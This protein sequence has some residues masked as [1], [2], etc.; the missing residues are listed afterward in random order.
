MGGQTNYP[1]HGKGPVAHLSGHR[2]HLFPVCSGFME[3]RSLITDDG[4]VLSYKTASLGDAE[5]EYLEPIVH[6]GFNI[7]YHDDRSGVSQPEWARWTI[8]GDL[9]RILDYDLAPGAED[10]R[11]YEI[12][13][14]IC[15][16]AE[17]RGV[18][19]L[20]NQSEETA[21]WLYTASLDD[22]K[23]VV[24]TLHDLGYNND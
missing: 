10:Y 17:R 9:R 6:D 11:N 1:N 20:V 15:E 18:E 23:K 22:A 5:Y 21:V 8:T 3:K 13:K 2:S 19:K 12:A 24:N 14:E 7:L 4:V 16:E